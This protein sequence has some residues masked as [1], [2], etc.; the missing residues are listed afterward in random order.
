M[1]QITSEMR[2]P[3]MVQS[4]RLS[5]PGGVSALQEVGH[6]P[7]GA[8]CPMLLLRPDPG[9]WVGGVIQ[10]HDRFWVHAF[11]GCDYALFSNEVPGIS[12]G[13]GGVG[14]EIFDE[15]GRLTFSSA[16]R[17][18]RIQ[19]I[20]QHVFPSGS[21]STRIQIGT[22][23]GLDQSGRRPWVEASDF[24]VGRW[25]S[26]GD[27]TIPAFGYT[28]EMPGN[29]DSVILGWRHFDDWSVW[30]NWSDAKWADIYDGRPMRIP[31]CHVP[32]V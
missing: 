25:A 32:G 6:A 10:F 17:F 14:I 18:P 8:S 12:W 5:G 30:A 26:S 9:A 22:G 19:N 7:H 13:D 23:V 28:L 21:G 29:G 11:G 16:Y 4:G 2:H 1:L 15:Q 27:L 3:A 20:V 31:M 24:T